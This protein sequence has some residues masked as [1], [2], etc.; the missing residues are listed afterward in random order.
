[1]H[2]LTHQ[3]PKYRRHR[4]SGHAFVELNGHRHYLGPF[5]TK[6]SKQEYDRLLS[7][8]LATGRRAAF[9]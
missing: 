5:G 2:R 7:E 8:S 6:A 1:M 4:A 3:A 9:N